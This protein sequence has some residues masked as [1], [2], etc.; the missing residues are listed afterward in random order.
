MRIRPSTCPIPLKLL[1][2][3]R[4]QNLLCHLQIRGKD[5]QLHMVGGNPKAG[6]P[7]RFHMVFYQGGDV[8]F[9]QKGGYALDGYQTIGPYVDVFVHGDYHK[10]IDYSSLACLI[11][12]IYI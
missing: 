5:V 2:F 4:R 12:L 3:E 8:V 1:F 7:G 10:D 9:L 6:Q 11:D